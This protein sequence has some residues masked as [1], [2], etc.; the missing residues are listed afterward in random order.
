MRHLR[1]PIVLAVIAVAVALFGIYLI[2]T[3]EL[4]GRIAAGSV[5]VALSGIVIGL[6]ALIFLFMKK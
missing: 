1:N 2:D 3:Y 6:F 4:A 5:M